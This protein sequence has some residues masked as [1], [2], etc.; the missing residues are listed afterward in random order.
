MSVLT[1]RTDAAMQSRFL[2]AL[3]RK[4]GIYRS[5]VERHPDATPATLLDSIG[6]TARL[7]WQY[8]AAFEDVTEAVGLTDPRA[9]LGL[10]DFEV[11]A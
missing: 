6:Q 3:R 5:H 10:T 8:G 1:P 7:A 9:V 4:G 2:R 11:P